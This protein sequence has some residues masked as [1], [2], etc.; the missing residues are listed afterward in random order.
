ME[1]IFKTESAVSP[2]V[3][4]MLMLVVTIVIAA[5]VS[6]FAGSLVSSDSSSPQATIQGSYSYSN[7]VFQLY[8]AGGDELSTQKIIVKIQQ[9]DEDFGGYGSLYSQKGS[10]GM[11]MEIV[12]KSCVCTNLTG[13]QCW[14]DSS[15]GVYNI[16]VF[17][18][19]DTMYYIDSGIQKGLSG[20]KGA[21][22][23]TD[24]V[25]K[26]LILEVTTTDGQMISKSK[27]IIEP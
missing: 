17:R 22:G 1:D 16:P 10:H 15:N 24:V 4:V 21:D 9:N 11:G 12:N 26:S 14:L 19:G 18:P 20:Y 3:G 25:G 6:G 7:N 13:G 5:V 23:N 27:V 2:V 8:H